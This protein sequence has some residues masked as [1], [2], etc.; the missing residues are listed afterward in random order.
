MLKT[1]KS[2]KIDSLGRIV[3]PKNIR[4]ALDMEPETFVDI[5]MDGERVILKRAED[6]SP[7]LVHLHGELDLILNK[8]RHIPLV[9]EKV[10]C[11]RA[12]IDE[13]F[14]TIKGS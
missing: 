14:N 12:V 3:I 1:E 8:Y 5:V 11:V 9:C 6:A 2:A 4:A 7:T 13:L 10:E